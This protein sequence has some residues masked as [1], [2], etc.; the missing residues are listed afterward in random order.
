MANLPIGGRPRLPV[1]PDDDLEDRARVAARE[2]QRADR[3]GRPVQPH[4]I[5]ELTD[6]PDAIQLERSYGNAAGRLPPAA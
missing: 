3:A 1:Y 4:L 5:T 6:Y 2:G